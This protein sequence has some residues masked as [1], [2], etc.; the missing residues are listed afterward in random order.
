METPSLP[1]AFSITIMSPTYGQTSII[2]TW[3]Q[4]PSDKWKAF[5]GNR[6]AI[7]QEETSAIWRRAV[8]IQSCLSLLKRKWT[9]NTSIIHTMVE[10]TTV[11]IIS[12]QHNTRLH[13]A[14]Q[15]LLTASLNE[16]YWIPRIRNLVKAAVT[17]YRYKVQASQQLMSELP[18]AR[19]QPS[20]PYLTTGVDCAESVALRL[21]TICSKTITKGYIAIF[22]FLWQRLSTLKLSKVSLLKHS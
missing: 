14:G 6:V 20:R 2:L 11:V 8:S 17:C 3:I 7:I 9:Y 4:R 19:V 21:V 13:H 10:R 15:Q 5:V 16:R 22:V 12:S 18:S 1:I